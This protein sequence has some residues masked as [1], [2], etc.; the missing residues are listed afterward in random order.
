M[1]TIAALYDTLFPHAVPSASQNLSGFKDLSVG[2]ACQTG[3]GEHTKIHKALQSFADLKHTEKHT[4]YVRWVVALVPALLDALPK[5]MHRDDG[6][7]PISE[8]PN[9]TY[10]VLKEKIGGISAEQLAFVLSIVP[11]YHN[12]RALKNHF[13]PGHAFDP[14]GHTLFKVAQYGMLY[15]IATDHGTKSSID[16]PTIVYLAVTAIADAVMLLNTT[17]HCHT[18][19]E[20]AVGGGMGIAVLLIGHLIS[21][22]TPLGVYARRAAERTSEVVGKLGSTMKNGQIYSPAPMMD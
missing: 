1:N 4:P 10:A 2:G 18:F 21:K 11:L 15:S 8:L 5:I 17:A 14:S 12:T 22:Y 20:I 7:T 13:W 6:P 19:A 3:Y 16:I 9:R